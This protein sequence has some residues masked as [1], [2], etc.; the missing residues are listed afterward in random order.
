VKKTTVIGGQQRTI[1]V[2]AG[3]DDGMRIRFSDF[4]V[5][6]RVSP[7]A[8]FRR[9][10]QDV[11]V[12]KR[13]SYP[14]AVLGTVVDVKT[15]DDIVK[16]KVRPGTESGSVLRLGGQGI[17]YPNSKRRGDQYVVFKVLV[18][19]RVSGK[20]KQLLEDLKKEL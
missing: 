1:K 12:E 7:S 16:L 15:I 20:A 10:G 18:P 11:Y 3:V 4:D 17:P 19:E 2:P 8:E 5:L 13:I 14:D 9:E 6:V